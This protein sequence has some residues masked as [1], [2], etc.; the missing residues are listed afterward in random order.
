[1]LTRSRNDNRG[2]IMKYIWTVKGTKIEDFYIWYYN[3]D[4]SS[5]HASSIP[6][7]KEDK[8]DCR[9]IT[10]RMLRRKIGEVNSFGYYRVPDLKERY[11]RRRK[12][13]KV[14]ESCSPGC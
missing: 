12:K 5:K 2:W 4:L 10:N 14:N 1:M 6:S 3:Y 13:K 9:Y 11:E 8:L 7:D